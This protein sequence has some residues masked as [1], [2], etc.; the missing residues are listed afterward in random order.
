MAAYQDNKVLILSLGAGRFDKEKKDMVAPG[1]ISA[2]NAERLEKKVRDSFNYK[3]EKSKNTVYTLTTYSAPKENNKNVMELFEKTPFVA[4]PLIQITDPDQIVVIGSIRS[5]WSSFYL[6]LA[7]S[8]NIDGY[9]ELYNIENGNAYAITDN[10]LSYDEDRNS[11]EEVCGILTGDKELDYYENRINEIFSVSGGIKT[12]KQ[13]F[14]KSVHIILIRYGVD[15]EQQSENY[16]RFKRINKALV[17][18]ATNLISFDISHSFRSI[19]LY[20]LVLLNYI[21]TIEDYDITIKHVFNG[22]FEAKE[23]SRSLWPQM[24]EDAAPIIDLHGVIDLFELTDAVRE[25]INTGN[26]VALTSHEGKD[27]KNDKFLEDLSLF[28]WATQTNDFRLIEKAITNLSKHETNYSGI[29]METAIT[30]RTKMILSVISRKMLKGRS[31]CE[32]SKMSAAE[33]RLVIAEWYQEQNR[34]G[35][36]VAT[37]IESMR[38]LIVPYYLDYKNN[39]K[40]K[41]KQEKLGED[42]ELRRAAETRLCNISDYIERQTNT[43]EPGL[44]Q[45]V[46]ELVKYFRLARPIRNMFAHNLKVED[47]TSYDL[48]GADDDFSYERE[49][50]DKMIIQFFLKRLRQMYELLDKVEKTKDGLNKDFSEFYNTERSIVSSGKGTDKRIGGAVIFIRTGLYVLSDY[51]EILTNAIN[52]FEKKDKYILTEVIDKKNGRNTV[53]AKYLTACL[54]KYFIEQSSTVVICTSSLKN[55]KSLVPMLKAF[56]FQTVCVLI[57]KEGQKPM[58]VEMPKEFFETE[59]L[60]DLKCVTVPE[61]I[62]KMTK[63]YEAHKLVL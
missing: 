8:P 46:V 18:G 53:Q 54:Q 27:Q 13:G 48:E 21:E 55:V 49:D 24:K 5:A 52:R 61:E 14:S 56:L 4:E 12:G 28:D 19:P 58:L 31:L 62:G 35:Q 7:V 15:D 6:G 3:D 43:V 1:K 11:F 60:N 36:A 40:D 45:C 22:C 42:E 17:K 20:N 50:S 38:S 63:G 30:D 57:L 26:A 32:F 25:F 9:R 23:E 41:N 2:E 39:N 51:K 33:K 16:S 34:Y 29:A 44:E 47:G 10:K 37:G 59:Y